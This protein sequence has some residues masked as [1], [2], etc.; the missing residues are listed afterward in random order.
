MKTILETPAQAKET[1]HVPGVFF[2]CH[3]CHAVKPV[4]TSGG[5]GYA[6][7]NDAL[8][9][10]ACADKREAADLLTADRF[11]GYVSGDGRH[12]TTW[13]GGKLG[14]LSL[15]AFHPWSRDRQYV[16][17][18]DLHGQSWHGTGAPSMWCN[19]RKCKA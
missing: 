17:A 7:I 11:T 19:L 4:Q 13:T 14:T 16:R 12:L 3:D 10:Y 18:H 1:R 5:T 8:I 15:G 9:C 6:Y 2:R